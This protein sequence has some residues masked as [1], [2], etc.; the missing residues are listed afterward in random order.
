[1]FKYRSRN[2]KLTRVLVQCWTTCQ[3]EK[4]LNEMFICVLVA[5]YGLHM[6]KK[7]HD[8]VGIYIYTPLVIWS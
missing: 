2:S 4:H 5:F 6:H 1:L 8:N 3:V 7:Y